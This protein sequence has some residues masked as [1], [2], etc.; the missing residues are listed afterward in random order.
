MFT[1]DGHI[2]THGMDIGEHGMTWVYT[3]CHVQL[4]ITMSYHNPIKFSSPKL[5]LFARANKA[6]EVLRLSVIVYN[7]N[8][9]GNRTEQ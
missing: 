8:I 9:P 2:S 3:G 5:D 4:I 6:L 1:R 7:D